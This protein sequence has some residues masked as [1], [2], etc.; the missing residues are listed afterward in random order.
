MLDNV[1]IEPMTESFILWRCLH[2]GPLSKETIETYPADAS[3]GWDAHR[4][5]NMPLLE[6]IIQTYGTCAM[7]ARDGEQMVGSLRFY[8]KA[9]FSMEGAGIGLC[10]QQAFPAGPSER[11]AETAFPPLD[12]IEEKT[13][14]VHCLM[15]GSPCQKENPYQR[16]GI[17]TRMVR[18]LIRWAQKNGWRCIEATAYEDVDIIYANT[19]QGGKSFWEKL[20]FRLVNTEIEPAFE[21]ENQFVKTMKEQAAAQGLNPE[22]IKNKYTMRLD[23]T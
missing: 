20:G 6:K 14:T 3:M 9:I 21:E 13:L 15:T 19:G 16:K 18:E 2:R 1:V 23:L 7:L 8:P 11:L 17:G 12:E 10:L 4:A 5:I 22:H